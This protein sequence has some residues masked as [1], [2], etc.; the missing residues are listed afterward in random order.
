MNILIAIIVLGVLVFVHELGHFLVAKWA[1]VY[2]EKF[3]IGFGPVL[4]RKKY[5]E[6]EYV[7]S[8]LPL[9][10]YVKMY[11]EQN[12]D[13]PGQETYDPAKEGRSFKDKSGWQKAAIIFAGPLFNVIFAILIFWGLYMTG[14]PSYSAIVGKVEQ[15]S[16][17]ESAGLK[18]GDKIVSVNNEKIRSWN[19]FAQVIADKPNEKVTITL[20]DNRQINLTVG[21]KE[22]ADIFGDK[23]KIGSIG[24]GLQIDAVIGE[25]V[26]NMAAAEA[27]LLKG[28]KI[29]SING[30]KVLSWNDSA[31]LIR[32]K[33]GQE[34]T[35]IVER[36]GKELP[37]K[38]TP[39]PTEQGSGENKKTVG[40]IGIAPIDGDITVRYGPVDA[41]IMGLE[42]SYELT[43]VIYLGFA[44]LIQREIPADSL[45]GPIL[46]VETAAQSA[47]SG[48]AALLIFMA[49]I[50]INLAVFNLLPIPVLDGGQLAII[51]AEGIMGRP[52]GEKALGAFQM[53]GLL[54]IISLMVFA[55]YNDIMRLIK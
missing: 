29:L 24:A 44:K 2:V 54:V 25:V 53:F 12:E 10:G 22:A 11:G 26:P 38:L 17:A 51:G 14:I 55:F 13:E 47:E 40:L 5:G 7:I 3:S 30:E 21:E 41:M 36:Q 52:L 20:S 39:K 49:A 34:L 43:K 31:D 28:D 27:G 4:L 18:A 35:V 37:F 1:G 9:G 33:P 19:E 50:S 23:E 8:A 6:T 46:I 32:S 42:K 45:G 15:G 16:I 48:F